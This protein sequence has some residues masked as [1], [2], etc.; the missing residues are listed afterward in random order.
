M[1]RVEDGLEIEVVYEAVQRIEHGVL[2]MSIDIN[3]PKGDVQHVLHEA[4]FV[5]VLGRAVERDG[6]LVFD[7]LK[8]EQLTE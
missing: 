3:T 8:L 4:S 6:V 1:G 2:G 5:D 7:Y